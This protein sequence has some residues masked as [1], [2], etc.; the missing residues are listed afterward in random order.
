M[1]GVR[2]VGWAESFTRLP[3]VMHP[4]SMTDSQIIGGGSVNTECVPQ[5]TT[6]EGSD[7]G[8]D[9]DAGKFDKGSTR[10]GILN[11]FTM[12]AGKRQLLICF[13]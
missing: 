10:E 1:R 11:R 3:P 13:R 7:I 2:V 8:D 6:D 9:V 12:L 5:T 4:A